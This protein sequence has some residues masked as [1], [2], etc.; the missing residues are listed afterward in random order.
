MVLWEITLATAYVLGLKR[1]FKLALQIQRRLIGPRHPKLR[2]FVYGRTRAVFDVVLKVQRSI[3]ERDTGVGW[4]LGNWILQSLDRIKPSAQIPR[5]PPG[6]PPSGRNASTNAKNSS[7][8]R[9][10]RRLLE[11]FKRVIENLVDTYLLH[12]EIHGLGPLP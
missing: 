2:R 7:L 1:T 5:P 9:F 3:Q 8:V 11:A 10:T 12:Q 4:S 6:I